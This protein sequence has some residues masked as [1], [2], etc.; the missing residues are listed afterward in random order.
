MK[1]KALPK[2]IKL[3]EDSNNISNHTGRTHFLINSLGIK[4]GKI[5]KSEKYVMQ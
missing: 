5:I 1:V 3:F 4:S 2:Y